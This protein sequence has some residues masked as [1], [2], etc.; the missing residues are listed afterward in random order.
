MAEQN[1]I[2]KLYS[3]ALKGL[4]IA[5]ERPVA[6]PIFDKKQVQGFVPLFNLCRRFVQEKKSEDIL[7][8]FW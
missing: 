7:I 1:Q 4:Q 8:C 5:L 3:K 6:N 2:E